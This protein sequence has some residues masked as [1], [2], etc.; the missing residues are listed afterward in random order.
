M[1]ESRKINQL[2]IEEEKDEGIPLKN[3]FSTIEKFVGSLKFAIVLISLFTLAM[4][5][6]TF[7]ESYYGTEFAGRTIYKTLPFMML[8]VLMGLSILYAAYL[9]LPPKKSLY[10]FY[11]IHSG[12]ILIVG[13][14]FITY[15]S[16]I[17]GN[18]TL[19]PLTP[20]R[21]IVL[22]SDQIRIT[23]L[24]T[25]EVYTYDLPDAAFETDINSTNDQITILKFLPY[26][27]K[28]LVWQSEN[29]SQ[30][31]S[32][33]SSSEYFLSNG[34]VSQD[35]VL[36]LHP[37]AFDFKSNLQLGP[38]NIHYLPA[39]LAACFG[40]NNN[41][42]I[43][44]WNSELQNC[45][46]PESQNIE[47]KKTESGKRF[48]VIKED[49]LIYT[50]FPDI[51]PF[52]LDSNF[53][54]ISDSKFRVFSKELFENSPNLFLFGEEVAFYD[55]D[56]KKWFLHPI[57]KQKKL[58]LP[59]MGFE[60]TLLNHHTDKIPTYVPKYVIPIQKNGQLLKGSTRAALISFS[61]HE[62]WVRNDQSITLT[63]RG[64]KFKIELEKKSIQLPYELSLIKF[65]MDTDP[66]TRN[67]ASYE[68]FIQL[69]TSKGPI[70]HHIYMN[71]PLKYDGLTFY[72]AS[73][74]E[75]AEN[76]Y[77]SVL[78]VNIDP[79]RPIK[80]FGSLL[81]V[82]GTIWHFSLR[83]KKPLNKSTNKQVHAV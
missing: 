59:W 41:S 26:S 7:F 16:G 32:F 71:H 42:K 45:F 69:F 29:S 52:P 77:G 81:L 50:F 24:N 20:K 33:N 54:T 75:V 25:K 79:G 19:P 37:K 18:L 82:L 61:G 40:E 76:T 62:Y 35:F 8:Q 15:F 11:T 1:V 58:D 6:G 28:T 36:S 49:N 27:E 44:L 14:S 78:S 67:P 17:D 47:L 57:S 43:I 38:L 80:Y 5:V 51:S 68:S 73:Y 48:M 10:G 65:K 60:L 13:G 22:H 30:L 2:K 46:Y 23:N 64:E 9:R 56:E 39:P 31:S 83:R 55:K 34:N 63:Y 72:Q 70:D 53:N 4:I 66:G 74:F 12:L 3:N 21:D